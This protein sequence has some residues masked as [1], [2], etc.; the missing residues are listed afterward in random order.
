MEPQAGRSQGQ[1]VWVIDPAYTTVEFK[2][3]NLFFFTVEGRLTEFAGRIVLDEG[4]V[5]RSSVEATIKAASVSTGNPRRDA[6][7]RSAD[8]LDAE[9]HPEIHFR[10]ASVEK[11]RDRDALVVTGPLTIL[12]KTRDVILNVTVVDR[13][14]SPRG[15]EVVY[16]T[17]LAEA[18][19]YDFGIAY[20]RGVIGRALKIR[21]QV[22]AVR[23]N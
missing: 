20:G 12:G 3:K 10:S 14:R 9:R 13:S 22:Q 17:A 2:V 11:G 15:E 19:R 8:F 7:L 6:H 1:T 23:E 18:D 21:I 4:D 5:R 16:Y